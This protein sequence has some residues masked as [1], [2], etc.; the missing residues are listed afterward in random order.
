MAGVQVDPSTGTAPRSK[1]APGPL[2][3][4]E[5]LNVLLVEKDGESRQAVTKMLKHCGYQGEPAPYH[6]F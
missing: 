6:I 2:M 1:A 3:G 4:D 5:R